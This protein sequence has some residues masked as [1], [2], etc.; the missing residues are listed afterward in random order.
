MLII[1]HYCFYILS[2]VL[3]DNS[4]VIPRWKLYFWRSPRILYALIYI[5]IILL[6]LRELSPQTYIV[7]ANQINKKI[8]ITNFLL[9]FLWIHH[10]PRPF[11]L[12]GEKFQIR[13]EN[14][15]LNKNALIENLF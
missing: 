3:R 13:T 5:L 9:F 6:G 7:I 8:I 11:R 15:E 10:L 2:V 14:W 12:P 1:I 4:A